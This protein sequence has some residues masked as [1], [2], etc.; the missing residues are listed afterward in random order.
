MG[1][2]PECFRKQH[3]VRRSWHPQ[4]SFAAWGLRAEE[5][6]RDHSLDHRLGEGSPLARV[7]DADGWVLLLGV[8]HASDTSLHLAEYRATW[9]GK[10]TGRPSAPM[11]V[12]GHKR[13]VD[14]DDIEIDGRDFV[15]IGSAFARHSRLQREGMVGQATTM[16]LP[17]R[18]L[19]DFAVAWMGA[20][21]NT[22][23][24]DV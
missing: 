5:V 23:Q 6:S 2:I 12:E 24:H 22:P 9:P 14:W 19:V 1:V 7:Y 4:V 13:W 17:Q 20:N 21:R 11:L 18:Q 3:G 10:R 15:T 8:T 16:L